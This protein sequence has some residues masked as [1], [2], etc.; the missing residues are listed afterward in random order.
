MGCRDATRAIKKQHMANEPEQNV[1]K[2]CLLSSVRIDGMAIAFNDE[3]FE[4]GCN[5]G[6]VFV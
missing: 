6:S 5:C 2:S 4:F 1:F 3:V